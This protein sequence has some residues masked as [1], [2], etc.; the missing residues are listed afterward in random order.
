MGQ[1]RRRLVDLILSLSKDE[2]VA[3]C[4]HSLD[5]VVRQAHHEVF[6]IQRSTS[7]NKN[8]AP[9]DGVEFLAEPK[10]SCAA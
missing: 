4:L 7:T 10:L 5:L 8:A 1:G 3:R 6:F 9:R 2:V